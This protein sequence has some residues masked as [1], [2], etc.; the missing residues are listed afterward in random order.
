MNIKEEEAKEKWCPM[1]RISGQ[2]D[3][4]YT[5][6]CEFFPNSKDVNCIGSNC[7]WWRPHDAEGR[8]RCGVIN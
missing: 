1:V 5:N 7:M 4:E 6:R 2:T 8:G 3:S